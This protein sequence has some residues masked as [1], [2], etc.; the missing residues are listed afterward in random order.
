MIDEEQ[1]LA[2]VTM[3]GSNDVA[4]VDYIRNRL[5]LRVPVGVRPVHIYM[6]PDLPPA[7]YQVLHGLGTHEAWIG[8]DGGDSVSVIDGATLKVRATVAVGKGHH[9]MAF[10]GDKAYV[11]NLT[12]NT[13]SVIDR[14]QVIK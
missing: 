8:N 5:A 14:R 2:Y 4:V 9:K 1:G 10:W 3:A 6:A 11:S 13:V 7:K 12:D